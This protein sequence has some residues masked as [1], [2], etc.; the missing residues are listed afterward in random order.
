MAGIEEAFY[1]L[2]TGNSGVAALISTRFFP[3]EIA[4][5][6]ALPAACYQV[7]TTSRE[8]DQNGADGFASP[9]IQITITGR[10]Y[11]EAKGVANAIRTGINGYRGMVGL[12]K[13]FGVFLENEYD[14][15]SNLETG[16]STVRQDYRINWRE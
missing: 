13:I 16:F 7:I 11:A 10:T 1:S 5:R 9:R 4:Q 3:L 12:V 15:S 8:Y 2:V 14:G 6:S